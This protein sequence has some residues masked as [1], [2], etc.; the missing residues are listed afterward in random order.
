MRLYAPAGPVSCRA[1][2]FD[3][4]LKI[5]NRPMHT[6]SDR[7]VL[8]HVV[9]SLW[10]IAISGGVAITPMASGNVAQASEAR[11]TASVKA[12]EEARDCVVNIHGQKTLAPDEDPL[13]RAEG[14]RKVNGMG[15]GIVIDERGY[16]I[17]NFHVVDGVAKIEVTFADGA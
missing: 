5:E 2:S 15:T 8:R 12:V 16:I 7:C 3:A 1:A 10:L 6:R 11:H 14:P 9:R 4:R 13:S 17:T